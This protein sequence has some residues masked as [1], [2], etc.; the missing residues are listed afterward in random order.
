MAIDW[1]RIQPK[2]LLQDRGKSYWRYP[3]KAV[4]ADIWELDSRLPTYPKHELV[5]EKNSILAIFD[6]Q[7]VP[8]WFDFANFGAT[9]DRIADTIVAEG[10]TPTVASDGDSNE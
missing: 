10:I 7:S 1:L 6:G 9:I 4:S 5:A 8:K 3:S 2:F